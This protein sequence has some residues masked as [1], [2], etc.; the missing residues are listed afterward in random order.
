MQ[1]VNEGGLLSDCGFVVSGELD[2]QTQV[3]HSHLSSYVCM[4]IA[5][6]PGVAQLQASWIE[7]FRVIAEA[8][9]ASSFQLGVPPPHLYKYRALYTKI[10]RLRPTP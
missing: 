8:I 6:L 9:P 4:G 2:I 5:L 3:I 1:I 7:A 10:K